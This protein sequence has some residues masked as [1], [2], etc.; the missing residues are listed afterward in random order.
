MRSL[1]GNLNL[2]LYKCSAHNAAESEKAG[3]YIL[4]FD[5]SPPPP[6]S[7]RFILFPRVQRCGGQVVVV[8]GHL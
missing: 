2:I 8:A 7:L 6:P 3:V 1:S 4:H 5:H